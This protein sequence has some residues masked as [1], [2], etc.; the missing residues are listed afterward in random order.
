VRTPVSRLFF[1]L[2]AA[3]PVVLMSSLG[4]AAAHAEP[5]DASPAACTTVDSVDQII[6]DLST[7]ADVEGTLVTASIDGSVVSSAGV[8]L[9]D[10]D[11]QRIVLAMPPGLSGQ[12]DV[13]WSTRSA[14]DGDEASGSYAF[15][16]GS[17]IDTAGC[18]NSSNEESSSTSMPLVVLAAGSVL[19][20]IAL[21][22]NVRHRVPS[23][24]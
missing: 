17:G 13:E 14:D 20:V 15:G 23:E 10:I 9:T 21:V 5:V 4:P 7:E 8:D 12:V 1:V 6:I 24:G 22:H 16:I 11:H 18:G 2:V 3:V 19:V